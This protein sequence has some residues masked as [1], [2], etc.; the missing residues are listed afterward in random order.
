METKQKTVGAAGT[1]RLKTKRKWQD[2]L[3]KETKGGEKSERGGV[4][5]R[6]DPRETQKRMTTGGIRIRTEGKGR[7]RKLLGKRHNKHRPGKLTSVEK[8]L[9]HDGPPV[10]R[11][12]P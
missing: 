11:G 9:H 3:R 7:K 1:K 12:K 6:G 5:R 8:K 2:E 10:R 4:R